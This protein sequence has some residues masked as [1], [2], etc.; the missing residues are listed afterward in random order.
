MS[1]L[2]IAAGVSGAFA[3]LFILGGRWLTNRLR[4]SETEWD[5]WDTSV[6]LGSAEDLAFDE[7]EHVKALAP[8]LVFVPDGFTCLECKESPALPHTVFCATCNAAAWA[9]ILA[10]S[11]PIERGQR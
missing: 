6:D 3:G 10:P 5:N 1:G 2:W 11:S 4:D 7:A 9:A 8:K